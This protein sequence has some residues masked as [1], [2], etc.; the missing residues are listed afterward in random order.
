MCFYCAMKVQSLYFSISSLSNPCS[1]ESG[2]V[3]V[4]SSPSV[5]GRTTSPSTPHRAAS[6]STAAKRITKQNKK[7]SNDKKKKRRAFIKRREIFEG[8]LDSTQEEIKFKV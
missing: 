3:S 2:S 5:S 4:K 8:M 7:K 1:T 6:P